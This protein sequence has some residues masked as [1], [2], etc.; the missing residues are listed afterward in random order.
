MHS[1]VATNF[2]G[3]QESVYR[4][5]EVGK[6]SEDAPTSVDYTECAYINLLKGGNFPVKG[7]GFR[8]ETR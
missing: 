3:T 8:T 4:D 2:T 7:V 5:S 6:L 1:I